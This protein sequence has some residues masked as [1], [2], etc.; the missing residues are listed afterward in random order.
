MAD[1][2]VQ[3]SDVA[4]QVADAHLP[5]AAEDVTETPVASSTTN[6]PATRSLWVAWLYLFDWYPSHYSKEEKRLLRKLDFVL[7][8]ELLRLDVCG[9][10]TT[11]RNS[12]VKTNTGH[13]D[14]SIVAVELPL[15]VSPSI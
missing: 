14:G 7:I 8:P 15:K 12:I 3:T 1:K 4:A 10:D 13:G 5:K 9:R 11:R 6:K 2:Q